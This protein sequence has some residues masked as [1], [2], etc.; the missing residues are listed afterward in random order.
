[1][2]T[3]SPLSWTTPAPSGIENQNQTVIP[4]FNSSMTPAMP[5]TVRTAA[6]AL[7]PPEI[8]EIAGVTAMHS[9]KAAAM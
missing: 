3:E 7:E 2:L 9:A 4:G 6:A 5:F 8:A 1:M